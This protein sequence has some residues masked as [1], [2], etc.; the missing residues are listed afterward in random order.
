MNVFSLCSSKDIFTLT[1]FVLPLSGKN[2]Q[3]GRPT[4]PTN[5]DP[6]VSQS[7]NHQPKKIHRLDLGLGAHMEK[8]CSLIIMLV[9]SNWK[10]S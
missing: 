3:S 10:G 2:V 7:L 5:L 4:K 8:I 6:W 9:L 1:T